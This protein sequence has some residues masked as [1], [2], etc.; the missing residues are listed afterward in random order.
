MGA[1]YKARDLEL[2]ETV[3]LKMLR[4]DAP[5]TPRALERF[6][7]E[8]KLARRVTH[9]NVA[10]TFDI[11]DHG[12]NKFLTMELVDGEA[13]SAILAREGKLAPQRAT[14]IAAEVCSGL[15]AAHAAGVVHRDLKPD[16]LFITDTGMIKVLDFGVA[17]V[18]ED[19][20]DD[21][22]TRTGIAVGTLSYMAPEQALGKR[23]EI[24]GRVDIF[25]LGATAFRI[26]AKRRVHEAET[27]AGILF[28]MATK[29]APPLRSVAPHV[30]EHVAAI[31]DLALA[32]KREDRYPDARVMQ[33]DVRAAMRGERPPFA[34]GRHPARDNATQAAIPAAAPPANAQR[35]PTVVASRTPT[36]VGPQQPAAQRTPTAVGP[37]QP[38]AQRTPTVVAPQQ[39]SAQRTPTVVAP[40][41]SAAAAATP[42]P[43]SVAPQHAA[44]AAVPAATSAERRSAPQW[45]LVVAALGCLLL[46]ALLWI[47]W[48][49][50]NDSVP[51]RETTALE[52]SEV[53]QV[54]PAGEAT[55]EPEYQAT[56]SEASRERSRKGQ[57]RAREQRKKTE[58]RIRERA[59][60]DAE[61]WREREKR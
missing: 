60:K 26:L 49:S 36:A 44:A 47:A 24:D 51:D 16:N 14:H 55:S 11:S 46:G 23:A 30:P 33:E 56:Q 43:A 35:T 1:V 53:P 57:E 27:D 5:M 52:A 34:S 38:S 54:S 19:V 29:E 2:D 58:E 50:S 45:R 28:A 17:R 13:L 3:A 31:V 8:V 18:L 21:V 6:R 25:A 61:R 10:R 59:K 40:Q 37:Q 41:Q 12:G 9:R 48:P 15:A 42:P 22:R 39:P 32:F 7:R 20:P 4:P